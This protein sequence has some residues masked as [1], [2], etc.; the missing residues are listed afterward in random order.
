MLKFFIL[1]LQKKGGNV[2]TI[3]PYKPIANEAHNSDSNSEKEPETGSSKNHISPPVNKKRSGV[4][5]KTTT[6]PS[7]AS[8]K[9]NN[10]QPKTVHNNKYS[11]KTKVS[12][13][14]ASAG[15][16][17]EK[18]GAETQS[19]ADQ[20]LEKKDQKSAETT[21]V[22]V[23]A[24]KEKETLKDKSGK[25]RKVNSR[26]PTPVSVSVAASD[27]SVVVTP[28]TNTSPIST[29]VSVDIKKSTAV[30]D[31]SADKVKKV[32]YIRCVIFDC[33]LY[34]DHPCYV[35]IVMRFCIGTF[36]LFSPKRNY[37]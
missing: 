20:K 32:Q 26:T 33:F 24:E 1:L 35:K 2:K 4:S 28:V 5:G 7:K 18:S 15:G 23:P 11:D 31:I 14:S 37:F 10:S 21:V 27:I 29:A 9:S 36:C 12:N 17:V 34:F 30:S 19:S 16:K 13:A 8:N 6:T 22:E 25:K 3:P